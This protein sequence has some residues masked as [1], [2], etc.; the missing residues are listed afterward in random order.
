V[1]LVLTGHDHTY[2]R[3]GLE[4]ATVYATSVS[5]SK[6]YELDRK[7]WM[8]RA[9]EDTQLFQV[10][11]ITGDKLFYEARTATGELYDAFELRKQAAGGNALIEETP[12]G[13]RERLR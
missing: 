3:S 5:G 6:M 10:I 1:D 8:R 13:V 4:G 9:A 2:G 7:A 11:T 12:S